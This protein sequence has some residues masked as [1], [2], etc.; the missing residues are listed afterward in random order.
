MDLK[1]HFN[2]GSKKRDPSS[3]TSASGDDPKKIREGSLNDSN[4]P[5]NV[6]TEGLSSPHFVKILYLC[7]KNVENQ[8]H[9]IHSKT[10]ETKMSQIKGEKHLM[11]LNKT[12]N[13]L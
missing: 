4:N 11:D 9:G 13:Y 8:I 7:N 1:K 2:T 12:V 6:F 10:E 3:G 5:D